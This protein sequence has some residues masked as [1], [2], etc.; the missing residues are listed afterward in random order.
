MQI[1]GRETRI[2]YTKRE[3]NPLTIKWL[4]IEDIQQ[5]SRFLVL[6]VHTLFRHIQKNLNFALYVLGEC[7][8]VALSYRDE[9]GICHSRSVVF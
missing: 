1:L 8:Y 7:I 5:T 9:T 3:K 6:L 2:G 4:E